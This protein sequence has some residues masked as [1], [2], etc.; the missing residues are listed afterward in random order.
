MAYSDKGISFQR[1]GGVS[2]SFYEIIKRMDKRNICI[3][4][5]FFNNIYFEKYYNVNSYFHM[6]SIGK[7]GKLINKLYL[8][9]LIRVEKCDILHSTYY[10][11]FPDLLVKNVKHVTT[12]HDMIHERGLFPGDIKTI[13]NKKKHIYSA[14]AIVT[15][16]QWTKRELLD[17]YPDVSPEK[18][19]VIYHGNGLE[20]NNE[21]EP[22][23]CIPKK[24]ILFIGQRKYYKNFDRFL[25]AFS[26]L[27]QDDDE[28]KLVC[29]GSRLDRKE[30]E[31]IKR[32]CLMERVVTIQC[33]DAELAFLYKNAEC[34]VYPSLYEGFGIPILESWS[35]DC[36]V[37]LSNIEVF[38][39]IAG[40]GAL[41]FDPYKIDEIVR[42]VKLV[43]EK[44]DLKQK[45][46]DIGK[47]RLSRYSWDKAAQEMNAVYKSL[48]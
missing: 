32:M 11:I 7:I 37:V 24:Y 19:H 25:E 26:V 8:L 47:Q 20:F 30:K 17:I 22:C 48:L 15:V 5:I 27:C 36:P 10:S 31:T 21:I 43:I 33:D 16:S 42:A 23:I 2:R 29:V 40:E 18:I 39:E 44:T 6:N 1:C 35:C 3:G 41:Y 28:L 14:D 45:L 46:C 12:I 38:K 4:A 34:F 13:I 9:V